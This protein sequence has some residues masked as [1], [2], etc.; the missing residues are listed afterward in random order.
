MAYT[1]PIPPTPTATSTDV[2]W[3]NWWAYQ[4]VVGNM[5][6]EDER[7]GRALVLDKQH[8][9]KLAAETRCAESQV[10]LAAAQ[11]ETARVL[12]LIHTTPPAEAPAKPWTDE[13]LVR[14]F[15]LEMAGTVPTGTVAMQRAQAYAALLRFNFEAPAA[16]TGAQ[17]AK[18]PR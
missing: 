12:E 1:G 8:A 14:A 5:R 15:M 2:Q 9:D 11:A 16:V 7:A 10:K 17:N 18:S 13:Q 4:T 3:Q 6:Y